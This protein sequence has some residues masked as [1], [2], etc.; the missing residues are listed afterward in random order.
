[1]ARRERESHKSI[2]VKEIFTPAKRT[3]PRRH[4]VVKSQDDYMQFDLFDMRR[5]AQFNDQKKWGLVGIE[6]REIAY[7]R[8]LKIYYE[9]I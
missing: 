5:L 9:K 3:F 4:V 6:W 7:R 2:L 8:F 1:M